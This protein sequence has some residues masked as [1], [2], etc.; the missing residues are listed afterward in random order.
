MP[1][2]FTNWSQHSRPGLQLFNVPPLASQEGEGNFE[3][4]SN[5]SLASLEDLE[6]LIAGICDEPEEDGMMM[7]ESGHEVD[8]SRRAPSSA[9]VLAYVA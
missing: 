1:H 5:G 4:G 6:D 7:D 9:L 2:S 3:L 8:W